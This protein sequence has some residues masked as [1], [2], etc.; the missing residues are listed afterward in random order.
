MFYLT[1]TRKLQFKYKSKKIDQEHAIINYVN[2]KSFNLITTNSNRIFFFK[3]RK[4]LPSIVIK[5]AIIIL[6]CSNDFI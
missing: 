5:I 1:W 3:N 4:N 6:F 2:A